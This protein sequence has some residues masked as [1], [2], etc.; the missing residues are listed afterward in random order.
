MINKRKTESEKMVNRS[1]L[2]YYCDLAHAFTNA[3]VVTL[4]LCI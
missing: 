2:L 4:D 3:N 1:S